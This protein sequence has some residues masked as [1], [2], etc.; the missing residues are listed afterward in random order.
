MTEPKQ[1]FH[2]P[3][4]GKVVGIVEHNGLVIVATEYAVFRLQGD[5]MVP[6]R[7]QD[8]PGVPV[9]FFVKVEG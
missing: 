2:I 6:I 9:H 4:R 1:W 5:E 7:F 3:E 8:L